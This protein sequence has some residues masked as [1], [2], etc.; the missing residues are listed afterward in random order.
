M[1]EQEALIYLDST[2][3]TWQ[4]DLENRLFKLRKDLF[5]QVFI[6]KLLIKK[7]ERV[8]TWYEA[9]LVLGGEKEMNDFTKTEELPQVN[10]GTVKSILA[11]YRGYE[12]ELMKLKMLLSRTLKPLAI[13]TLLKQIAA[14]EFERQDNLHPLALKLFLDDNLDF[15]VKLSDDNQTG[16][17]ISELKQAKKEVISEKKDL[18]LF[19]YFEKDLKRILKSKQ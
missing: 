2:K 6:P 4:E 8:E 13:S 16:I 12:A 10:G 19:P 11:L 3:E 15:D 14:L 7:A 5:M 17:I 9:S 1:T 18:F